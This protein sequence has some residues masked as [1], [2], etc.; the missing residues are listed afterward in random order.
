MPLNTHTVIGLMSGTSVDGLDAACCRIAMA[1][2]EITGRPTLS[3]FEVLG[4]L[5]HRFDADLQARL[6]AFM[7]APHVS[8]AEMG[9]LNMALGQA[10]GVLARDLKD[11]M[12]TQGVAVDFVASHGQTVGHFPPEG[13]ALG[14]TIQLG[15]PSVIAQIA[16]LP[17]VAD[18][19]P[20][21]MALGGHGAPLV[22]FAD[23]LLL[24]H[25][26]EH[27][28]VQNIGGIANM[29]VVPASQ[30]GLTPLAFDSGPGNMAID[31]AMRHFYDQPYDADGKIA[32]CGTVNTALLEVLL[33]DPYLSALPPKSTGRERYG[34]P[35]VASLLAQWPGSLPPEDWVATLTQFTVDSIAQAYQQLIVPTYPIKTVIVGGGG[36]QNP[37]LMAGLKSALTPMGITLSTHEAFG[38]S[39]QYKE[40]IAFALLGYARWMGLAANIP[41]C[42]GAHG[43]ALLGGIWQTTEIHA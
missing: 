21:D 8:L 9:A 13:G 18:F 15:E 38:L 23:L 1:R 25:A 17:V 16:G 42:T 30:S 11:Q 39:S 31:A 43:P 24:G 28:A 4:T 20:A 29:T 2:D 19:R 33:A 14:S 12:T 7:Q 10:F 32:A 5:S 34:A 37:T 40:A 27:R 3:T 36:A 6:L 41:A 35:F 22:P 26:T